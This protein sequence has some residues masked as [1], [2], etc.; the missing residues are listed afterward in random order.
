[1]SYIVSKL[2]FVFVS[3]ALVTSCDSYAGNKKWF[4]DVY[5]S[6][7]SEFAACALAVGGAVVA[8]YGL[9]TLC[10]WLFTPSDETLVKNC[11]NSLK[12][13]QIYSDYIDAIENEFGSVP[14]LSEKPRM[15]NE[16]R[17]PL[18]YQ[19]AGKIH[20]KQ[21]ISTLL[22]NLECVVRGMKESHNALQGRIYRLLKNNDCA[23]VS[24]FFKEMQD[25]QEQ[26]GQYLNKV[27][28]AYEFLAAHIS[29]F[30]LF[31]QES[32]L[33]RVYERELNALDM[34]GAYNTCPL[35]QE[36]R[37]AVMSLG[38][39][40]TV[41]YPYIH[42]IQRLKSDIAELEKNLS[43]LA[44]N[45][46]NRI[47][48]ASALLNKLMIISDL[49]II[50]DSYANELRE[51][52]KVRIER[53]KIQIQERQAAALENQSW[54]M[55]EQAIQLQRQNELKEKELRLEKERNAILWSQQFQQPAPQ[56]HVHIDAQI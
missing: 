7:Q 29:F 12:D 53:E 49:L 56:Y 46:T 54:Q 17:E 38:S 6:N 28:F 10:N 22:Y 35:S 3:C 18:L 32:S 45:Y 2:I 51:Q 21:G 24:P 43:H 4:K 5:A 40:H 19:L 37:I 8:S 1:M 9:Y 27:G 26:S 52:E 23:I 36:L 30:K 11:R 47:S 34:H 16:V 39:K 14:K 55:R 50:E 31:E 48:A 20:K 42:Y 13:A 33:I 25:L 44:Y 41:P 15:L